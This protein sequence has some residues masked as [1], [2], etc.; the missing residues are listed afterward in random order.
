MANADLTRDFGRVQHIEDSPGLS[1]TSFPE[2]VE[3]KEK[4]TKLS[5]FHSVRL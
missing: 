5:L 1:M 4:M 3:K 2:T